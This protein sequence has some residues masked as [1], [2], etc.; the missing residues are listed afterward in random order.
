MRLDYH[1]DLIVVSTPPIR[2]SGVVE[3]VELVLD[4]VG[5]GVAA[6][7]PVQLQRFPP[8]RAGLLVPAERG[9]G[10][11]H[12]V[13]GLRD[14]VGNAATQFFAFLNSPPQIAAA[15]EMAAAKSSSVPDISRLSAGQFSAVAEG[16][17]FQKIRTPICL[18]YHPSSP[19]TVEEVIARARQD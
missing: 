13:E 12:A 5:V 9:I 3:V 1:S 8:H 19:L 15:K 11:A 18:S 14:M 7:V 17:A 16:L 4:T 2:D 10:V 6:L